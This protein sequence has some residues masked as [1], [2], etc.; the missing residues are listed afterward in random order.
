MA[1]LKKCIQE[2]C[3][4]CTY[5]ASVAG[6]WREQVE[7]CTVQSCALWPVRPMTMSTINAN[8]KPRTGREEALDDETELETAE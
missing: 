8:R 4:T 1:S 5:D 3:K 6:T 7:N 2:H